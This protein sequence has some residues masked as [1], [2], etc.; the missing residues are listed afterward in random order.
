MIIIKY[1]T[2]TV[3]SSFFST[4]IIIQQCNIVATCNQFFKKQLKDNGDNVATCNLSQFGLYTHIIIYHAVLIDV[5]TCSDLIISHLLHVCL[6]SCIQN[7]NLQLHLEHLYCSS[8][9]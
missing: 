6:F 9:P 5:A 1:F 7:L 4:I 8:D 3:S 2:L